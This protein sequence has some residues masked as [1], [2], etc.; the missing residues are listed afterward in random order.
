[1]SLPENFKIIY[2]SENELE[3]LAVEVLFHGQD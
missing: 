3:W 2:V 1:M